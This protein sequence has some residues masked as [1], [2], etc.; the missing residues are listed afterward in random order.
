MSGAPTI[1]TALQVCIYCL[2]RVE[3]LNFAYL[4]CRDPKWQR[5]FSIIW[6]SFTGLV[7]LASSLKYFEARNSIQRVFWYIG[8]L[9]SEELHSHLIKGEDTHTYQQESV[10]V[11]PINRLIVVVVIARTR[12]KYGAECVSTCR[13]LLGILQSLLFKCI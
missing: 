9:W 5:K 1:P 12:V 4:L 2:D 11:S 6:A 10:R 13:Q 3:T 8:E 7:I